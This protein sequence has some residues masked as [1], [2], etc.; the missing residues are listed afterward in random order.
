M[1]T[2][3]L[4]LLSRTAAALL[5]LVAAGALAGITLGGPSGGAASAAYYEYCPPGSS[6]AAYYQYCPPPN[7][8]PDCSTVTV[9]PKTLWPP[10]HALVLVTLA[11][12][13]DP[14]GD[15][16]ALAITGV[17]QDEP[18]NGTGDGDTS[19]DAR[20]GPT[21]GSVRLRAERKGNADGRVYRVSFTG[22]D[23]AGGSCAGTVTVGVPHDQG[24][25][26]TP[27]DSRPP[28]FD[29]LGP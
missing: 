13:T 19:P 15:P 17:T 4:I 22:S 20:A 14:D 9:A 2:R 23:G 21:A 3:P 27:V 8:P 12:G 7:E 1:R 16:V 6:A 11:G 25:G 10:N 29:S 18:L 26:S 5:V 28:S 24:K